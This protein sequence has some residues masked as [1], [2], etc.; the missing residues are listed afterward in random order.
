MQRT[1]D[2]KF[3]ISKAGIAATSPLETKIKDL[4]SR[5]SNFLAR[6]RSF[7]VANRIGP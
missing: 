7:T 2:L 6:D 5:I 3:E 4:E 1:F